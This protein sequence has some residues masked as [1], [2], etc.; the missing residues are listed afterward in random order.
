MP[1]SSA[2]SRGERRELGRWHTV[3]KRQPGAAAQHHFAS[4]PLLISNPLLIA[5]PLHGTSCLTAPSLYSS[6][7]LRNTTPALGHPSEVYTG[8]ERK[9]QAHRRSSPP[10]R[11]AL[12]SFTKPCHR[13]IKPGGK[14]P[15]CHENS[16]N[17]STV[18]PLRMNIQVVNFQRCK[19]ACQPLCAKLLYFSR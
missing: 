10:P 1:L 17:M 3:G 16:F 18:S 15:A 4:A 9:P 11:A 12:S 13:D 8:L 7:T 6:I 19:C 2:W 14:E 5:P